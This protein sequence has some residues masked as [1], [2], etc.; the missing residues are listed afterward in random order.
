[1]A[2]P[3]VRAEPAAL[4]LRGVR[5]SYPH[6]LGLAR[7]EVLHGID[8]DLEQGDSLGL[9]GPN[10]SGK[11]TLLRL[12]AGVDRASGGSLGVLGATPASAEVRRRIG[13][14]PE[15]SP[16]PRE[17]RALAAL[18]LVATLHGVRRRD[19]RVRGAELLERVGLG[20]RARTPLS[21]FSRGML[22][23]FAIAQALV[24]APDLVLLDEPTAGLDAT[25]FSVLGELLSEAGARGAALVVS[26]HL[27]GDL[28]RHCRRVAVLI[29]GT[30]A[31][32]GAPSELLAGSGPRA[33]EVDGLDDV[34]LAALEREVRALGGSWGGVRPSQSALVELY[35]RYASGAGGNEP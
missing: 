26:S 25:G 3:P 1:M 13:F 18:E 35:R 23:R 33:I 16:F 34:A 30:L 15:D 2:E 14:C 28:H 11:S 12:I 6:G 8:L 17:L 29:G 9:V 24:H 19:A 31:A 5:K 4:L 7:R 32:E 10:G 21:R 27:L 20:A 22:R